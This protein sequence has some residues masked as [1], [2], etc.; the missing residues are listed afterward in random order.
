MYVSY[1]GMNYILSDKLQMIHM[2]T[3][4]RQLKDMNCTH[5]GHVT[6][7]YQIFTHTRQH[8]YRVIKISNSNKYIYMHIH[9]PYIHIIQLAKVTTNIQYQIQHPAANFNLKLQGILKSYLCPRLRSVLGTYLN[10]QP[11]IQISSA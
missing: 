3:Y 7:M 2:Y 1:L 5:K 4:I 8:K 6:K 9:H 11:K 10:P